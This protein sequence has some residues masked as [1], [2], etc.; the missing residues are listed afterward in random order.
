[1]AIKNYSGATSVEVIDCQYSAII[2][3]NGKKPRIL[4]TNN[5]GQS[6]SKTFEEVH[7]VQCIFHHRIDKGKPW[8]NR[9]I[10]RLFKTLFDEWITS[11]DTATRH[12]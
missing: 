9:K 12:S 4:Y 8:Q 2:N 10:E 1:M 5:G 11:T 7:K 6:V 3:N